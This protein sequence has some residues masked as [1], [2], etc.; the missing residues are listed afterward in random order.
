M[1]ILAL[2]SALLGLALLAP[3]ANDPAAAAWALGSLMLLAFAFEHITTLA[4]L[5]SDM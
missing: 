5:P 4:G 1:R 2:C 3:T